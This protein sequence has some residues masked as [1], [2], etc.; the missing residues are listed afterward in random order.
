MPESIR[1][2]GRQALGFASPSEHRKTPPEGASSP[3]RTG[4]ATAPLHGPLAPGHTGS[5]VVGVAGSWNAA[6][7]DPRCRS[8]V[9]GVLR[10]ADPATA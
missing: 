5:M 9:A 7:R 2:S 3:C 1:Q 8:K 6:M 4:G 10:A